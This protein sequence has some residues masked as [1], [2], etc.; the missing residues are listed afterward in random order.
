MTVSGELVEFDQEAVNSAVELESAALLDDL[1][2][3]FLG[4]DLQGEPVLDQSTGGHVL[5]HLAREADRMADEL[6][7]SVGR[8]IPPID[9][10]R[11]W[12]VEQGGLRPGA[13]LIEDFVESSCRL[14]DAIDGVRDWSTL[15]Q[16]FSDIPGRRLVQLIVHHADLHRS[17]ESV[18]EQQARAAL[19]QL[20]K[21]LPCELSDVRLVARSHQQPRVVQLNLGQTVIEG[22]PRLL[23]AWASGRDERVDASLPAITRRVWF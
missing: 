18:P 4:I 23:L 21:V 6:L 8:P 10:D 19:S 11:R 15:D 2:G 7:V 22:D 3:G 17:W 5:T 14:K 20:P 16:A 9:A 12:D 1:L 13:V